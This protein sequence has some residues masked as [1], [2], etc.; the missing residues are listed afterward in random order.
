MFLVL[1]LA[2]R[3]PAPGTPK[4]KRR[5]ADKFDGAVD[6]VFDLQDKITETIV[7]IIEPSV[8]GAEIERITEAI[9]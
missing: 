6:D 5:R 2:G 1:H 8:R 7:G 9:L 4:A 3:L